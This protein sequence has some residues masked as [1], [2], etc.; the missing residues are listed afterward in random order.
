MKCDYCDKKATVFLTQLAEGQMKKICLC[1][2]CA[3]ERGVTDP[4]GFSMADALLGNFQ[5]AVSGTVTAPTAVKPMG[6]GKHCPQCG[7]SMEDFQ[8]VRRFGC[9]SCYKVFA[10]ELAPMLRGMHKGATHVGKVPQGLI[11]SHFRIQRIEELQAKLD[12]AIASESYE[13]AAELRD[14]IRKL[15]EKGVGK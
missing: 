8:K 7:F 5:K 15:N 1:E 12:Q 3:K 11:E 2:S 13:E 9:A 10:S 14:E 4:T 6:S